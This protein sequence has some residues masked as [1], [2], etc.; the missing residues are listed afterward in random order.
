MTNFEKPSE[1]G[2]GERVPPPTQ[3]I[4]LANQFESA[5][6]DMLAAPE[7]SEP[8]LADRLCQAVVAVTGVEGA[9]I[10]VYL[11]ADIAIPVGASDLDATVG[12]ALQFTVREGPCFSSYS[13]RVPVLLPDL[14][15][16]GSRAWS[17]WPTYSEQ[18]VRL[19][20]YRA[21]FAYPLLRSGEAMGS[22]SLYQSAT[23]A[24]KGLEEFTGIVTRVAEYLLDAK[25]LIDDEGQPQHQWMNGAT[26]VRRR[27]VWL[28][29]GMTLQANRITPG[30]AMELLR[31]QAFSAGRLLD[32]IAA[33]IVGGLLPVPEL[34][35]RQ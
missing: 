1:K 10:S 11:G 8:L 35:S 15:R 16:P 12:E 5:V 19:T 32:E 34:E 28:A 22:L 7:S 31:A 13:Q 24:P 27:R 33:D 9:A 21:V 2:P 3:N 26:A 6:A 29:Q 25:M 18:L 30:Q 17:D 20:P 14:D 23:G 4:S